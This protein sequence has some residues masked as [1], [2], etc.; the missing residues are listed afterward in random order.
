MNFQTKSVILKSGL[1]DGDAWPYLENSKY[2]QKFPYL[3]ILGPPSN[4]IQL[5]NLY[6]LEPFIFFQLKVDD[7]VDSES[8]HE[9]FCP[10]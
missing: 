7:P 6:M 2:M 3:S 9:I 8:S 4:K 10:Y 1:I 5:A